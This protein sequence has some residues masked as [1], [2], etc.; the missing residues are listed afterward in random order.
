[1]QSLCKSTQP[2]VVGGDSGDGVT[3]WRGVCGD[4]LNGHRVSGTYGEGVNGTYGEGVSGTYGEGVNGTYGEGV[5]G[6]NGMYGVGD[7][8]CVRGM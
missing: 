3:R 7:G 8:S 2:A 5:I 4:G 1:M 6:V